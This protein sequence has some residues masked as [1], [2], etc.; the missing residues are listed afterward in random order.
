MYFEYYTNYQFNFFTCNIYKIFLKY[1][2]YLYIYLVL[3]TVNTA[4]S[5]YQFWC[6]SM[7]S[8]LCSGKTFKLNWNLTTATNQRWLAIS[9]SHAD[10]AAAAAN[11]R[12]LNETRINSE[13]FSTVSNLGFSISILLDFTA[14]SE[15][16]TIKL[17]RFEGTCRV[18]R[19]HHVE[20]WAV[21]FVHFY[22]MHVSFFVYFTSYTFNCHF[23][24]L[25][26]YR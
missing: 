24:L 14:V 11:T 16:S 5:V 7:Y 23:C 2:L 12:I 20:S 9:S 3:Y 13:N 17:Y 8:V 18:W 22:S 15:I 1:K 6:I 25:N 4:T 19:G 10:A 21:L 26:S